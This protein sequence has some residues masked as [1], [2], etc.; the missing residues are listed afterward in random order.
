MTNPLH[1][2]QSLKKISI[3]KGL[4]ETDYLKIFQKGKISVYN[5]N[6]ILAHQ[7][8]EMR[9]VYFILEGKVKI[10][11]I[12]EDGNQILLRVIGPGQP[13]AAVAVLENSSLPATAHA[14]QKTVVFSLKKDTLLEVMSQYAVVGLQI[15]QL[16]LKRIAELQQRL[17]EMA[18]E[19]V[20]KR[21]AR[22]LLRFAK[23]H[24]L[25]QKEGL[26][27]DFP[28]TRQDLAEF[29]GTTLFTVSRLLKSWEE[30]GIILSGRKKII[31][32]KSE[33]LKSFLED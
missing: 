24:G 19:R 8:E 25:V 1:N 9:E 16:L 22:T 2:S 33:A 21:I 18:T 30:G 31:I 27:I 23:S 5:K 28:L 3:F 17:R 4:Q 20:E 15:T 13:L 29:T 11:Q 32:Y 14:L 7:G 12:G 26:L 6:S 10:F